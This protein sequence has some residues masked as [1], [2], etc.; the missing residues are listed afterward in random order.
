[1]Q[2]AQSSFNKYVTARA[3]M[4]RA[5]EKLEALKQKVAEAREK[6]IEDKAKLQARFPQAE[7]PG[8]F[9]EDHESTSDA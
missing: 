5:E 2:R 8:V 6:A 4:Q 3:K 1:M 7:L 9:H